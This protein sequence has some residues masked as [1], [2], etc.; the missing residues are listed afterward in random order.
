MTWRLSVSDA[1]SF[2]RL[3][4]VALSAIAV[5][6]FALATLSIGFT[7]EVGRV[8]AIWPMNA[9]VLAIVLRHARR[10]WPAILMATAAGNL[11]AALWT[12]DTLP[13]ALVLTAGNIAEILLC[14]AVLHRVHE[15]VDITK[16]AHLLR[17]VAVAGV[18][19][20]ALSATL[21]AIA[22]TTLKG[23]DFLTTMEVWFAADALGMLIFGPA[24]LTLTRATIREMRDAR[25]FNSLIVL[26]AGLLTVLAATF[27]QSSYP[28]LFV[29][30]P[31]LILI[32]FRAGVAGVGLGLMLTAAVAITCAVA[33]Q[34][35]IRLIHDSNTVQ[36]MVLQLYLV[37]LSL[38][39]LPVAAA[40]A[41]RDRMR[42]SLE[43]AQ[44]GLVAAR[45][46][47]E[48]SEARFR[49]MADVSSD[50]L[51]RMD[52]NGVIHFVSPSAKT[53]MG[54]DVESLIGRTTMTLT[55]PD[56]IPGVRALFKRLIQLGPGAPTQSY[57][58]RV[59][60]KDGRWL[61]LE[62]IPLV[63]FDADGKP[64]GIQDSARDITAR[65]N[66]EL[67]IK[68]ARDRAEKAMR[69]KADF[70]ANMSHEIRTPLNSIIGFSGL[71]AASGDLQPRDRHHVDIIGGAS[72][73]LLA[74]VNDVLDF[75]SLDSGTIKLNERAFDL[76]KLL[77]EVAD[78]FLPATTEKG[79]AINVRIEGAPAGAH[80]GDDARLR[81]VLVNLIGNAI[82][83][84]AKGGITV[85][86]KANVPRDGRQ[87]LRI[88]VR[89]TGIGIPSDKQEALFTRFTQADSSINRRFGGSGLGLAISRH[90]V[91][92]MGGQ[93]G[94]DS[95]EG[96]GTMF[97]VAL[98][99]NCAPES[100]LAQHASAHSTD[101]GLTPCRLLVVDD[102]DLNRRLIAALLAPY[103]FAID[104][105]ADGGEAIRALETKSYDLILMDVQ[106][107]G[108][109]GLTA[110]RTIR[111]MQHTVRV[112]I[113]ALTAQA[114]PDQIGAC[115]AAGMD[116]YVAKPIQPGALFAAIRKW[117]G[118]AS[119]APSAAPPLQRADDIYDRLREK[120]IER[121]R[122]E[123][124]S[125]YRLLR[126]PGAG[127][128]KD[129]EA[130]VHRLAGTAGTL[131]F[132][133]LGA[134]AADVDRTLAAGD[135]P[136]DAALRKLAVTLEALVAA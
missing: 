65:K 130:I 84:T 71:L 8:A 134:L 90:L 109:D 92:L 28:L 78:S 72:R 23:E 4:A 115:R 16:S 125:L 66:A 18:A 37:F 6:C 36:V 121:C 32:A 10:S 15:P 29:P 58:F 35:P 79:L 63:L 85:T 113:V 73:S 27:T 108:I 104:E 20:P 47:A 120:F 62:G 67:Q 133:E 97:W 127:G 3:S 91:E 106:M 22:L 60:H 50:M 89:D 52:M 49:Q 74:I 40:L 119:V 86:L 42:R 51:A 131:G 24:A 126:T 123:L 56:D 17:F 118:R 41:E 31:V 116:D 33:G 30:G 70:L 64:T 76:S 99:L 48:E 61:W 12:G 81:Q 69:A 82:K 112:P 9:L 2:R 103:G 105:A 59:R 129:L 43:I 83:F 45:A 136:N 7:Q 1:G 124:R 111:A 96:A 94:L 87:G 55:H 34:G 110:A 132:A 38:T 11:A 19:A 122:A 25:G 88:E 98:D 53:I 101:E 77:G 114:L 21:A 54:Y 100:E 26:L 93:I 102:V 117:A 68:D 44:A 80:A 95:V 107:P 128:A 13:L 46:Q 57:E 14:A 39:T 75:S 5:T 135:I